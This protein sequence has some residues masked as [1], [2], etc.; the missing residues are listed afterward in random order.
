MSKRPDLYTIASSL[1][2]KY[3]EQSIEQFVSD[4]QQGLTPSNAL[5]R[6]IRSNSCT[7]LEPSVIIDLL[8]KAYL[9]INILDV[10]GVIIDS[11]Y[12]FGDSKDMD[13]SEFDRIVTQAYENPSEW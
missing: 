13:D 10:S 5:H 7:S 3:P 11:G 4:V 12:P 1:I 2:E 9:G 8:K 6:F